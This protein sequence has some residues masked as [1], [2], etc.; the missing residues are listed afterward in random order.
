MDAKVF[1]P[2]GIIIQLGGEDR[3]L[4][5]DLNA[6]AELEKRFGGIEAAMDALQEGKLSA[7]KLVLWAGLIH[8][9]TVVDALT[10]EPVSY[11]ITPHDVGSW[12][13][14]ANMPEITEQLS[15]AITAALPPVEEPAVVK[16]EQTT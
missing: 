15:K 5:Y 3:L 7:L 2:E 1:K 11:G 12:M 16:N 8:S 4:A 14:P 13:T 6:F 10:G 9:C